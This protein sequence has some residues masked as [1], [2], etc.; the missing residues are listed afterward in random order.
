MLKP[1]FL[2]RFMISSEQKRGISAAKAVENAKYAARTAD[3]VIFVTVFGVL[4][5]AI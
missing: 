4:R 3:S 2:E 5:Q 1:L